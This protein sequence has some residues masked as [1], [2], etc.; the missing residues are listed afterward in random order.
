MVG[1][2][3]DQYLLSGTGLGAFAEEPNSVVLKNGKVV[4]VSITGVGAAATMY[5]FD[6]ASGT[7]TELAS[8]ASVPIAPYGWYRMDTPHLVAAPDGGFIL[9][10]DRPVGSLY[11]SNGDDRLVMQKYNADG[12]SVG[13]MKT[14]ASGWIDGP[15]V[16]A[17]KTGFFVAYQDRHE[18][19]RKYEYTGVFYKFDGT[20]QKTVDFGTAVP[21]GD[22]LKNGNLALSWRDTDGVHVQIFK[23]N[24][25]TVGGDKII[26]GSTPLTYDDRA[27]QVAATPD[28]GFVTLFRLGTTGDDLYFQLHKANGDTKGKLVK[29]ALPNLSHSGHND[30][31]YD[32]AVMKDGN[33][34]IAWHEDDPA[35]GYGRDDDILV[36]VYSPQGNLIFGPQIAHSPIIGNQEEMHL[37]QLKNGNVLL[38]FHDDNV[39]QFYYAE[40]TQGVIIKAPDYFW[41]GDARNNTKTGTTGDDVLLGLGGDDKISGGKGEDYIRGGAGDDTLSGG[42]KTDAL[43]GEAG[44]DSLSGDK[45][46]DTLFGGDGNDTLS[47]GGGDDELRGEAGGDTIRGGGG[48]DLAYGGDGNDKM[49]GN[50]GNDTMYGDA[51]KDRLIGGTGNDTLEGGDDRDIIDGQAGN[52][53]LG[54][55]AGKDVLKGGD[56]WDVLR[57]GD[58]NDVL[59]GG[60][61][62]DNLYGDKGNDRL[63][64]EDGNDTF[65]G[66]AGDDRYWGGGDAD[67][68]Q[69]SGTGFDHDRIKDFEIGTDVL[70]MAWLAYAL[71]QS[72]GGSIKVTDVADG[73]KFAADAANWV[74]IE[75]AT[76]AQLTEGVDYI[77]DSPI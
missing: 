44:N 37:T 64:G 4:T 20:K 21:T 75:N 39:K 22:T 23:P 66:E 59:R 56:G 32:I 51:G 72:G 68:F 16:V 9:I 52:D 43:Y 34:V 33:F 3:G 18:S 29:I 10:I 74:I 71:Q 36:A 41:E 12:A 54:G 7:T 48:N 60:N 62:S 67:T 53:S 55:G 26:P 14:L 61:D 2:I 58:D 25:Q 15:E 8:M 1:Y 46:N 38:T 24:G 17:T 73:V 30:A 50:G 70:N 69:F 57:G 11:A 35:D 65:Y 6:P 27:I 42:D 40:S 77:I 63:Y 5:L 49:F 47:G 31:S 19:T 45:G 76:I 13:P 28:G